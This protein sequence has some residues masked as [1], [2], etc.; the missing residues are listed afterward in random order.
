MRII[1]DCVGK[2]GMTLNYKQGKTCAMLHIAGPG[3]KQA[4][5]DVFVRNRALVHF[6][7]SYRGS[8]AM[9]VVDH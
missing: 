3:S 2:R 9:H 8:I 6:Q 1:D 7:T 5:Q 4:K